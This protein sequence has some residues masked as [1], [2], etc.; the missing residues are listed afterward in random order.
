MVLLQVSLLLLQAM[1]ENVFITF[2]YTLLLYVRPCSLRE[3]ECWWR[4]SK[5]TLIVTLADDLR[6]L[7]LVGSGLSPIKSSHDSSN[8]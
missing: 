4:T 3:T 5:A 8:Y 1:A 2:L 7:M 6:Y